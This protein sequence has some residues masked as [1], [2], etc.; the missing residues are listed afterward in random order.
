MLKGVDRAVRRRLGARIKELRND[1]K[2]TQEE[3][4]DRIGL[5]QKYVSALECGQK[6]PSWETLVILAH[7]AFEIRLASLMFGIDEDI[8]VEV[9]NLGDVLAGRPMEARGDL[10]RGIE[11]VL[12]AGGV[13]K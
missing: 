8:A 6:S 12:R 3:V 10:L 9:R 5:S 11:L 2:L 13:P 1:R 4:A 7:K